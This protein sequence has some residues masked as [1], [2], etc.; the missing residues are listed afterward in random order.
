M[1]QGIIHLYPIRLVSIL[2]YDLPAPELFAWRPTIR[3]LIRTMR[4]PLTDVSVSTILAIYLDFN[5]YRS[6]MRQGH[7]DPP[8]TDQISN[9]IDGIGK[10]LPENEEIELKASGVES[11]EGLLRR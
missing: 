6:A 2:V 9:L 7:Y 3:R 10:P 11:R 1:L 4:P 8:Q 5:G